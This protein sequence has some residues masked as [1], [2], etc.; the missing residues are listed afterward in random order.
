MKTQGEIEMKPWMIV[1]LCLA[2]AWVPIGNP[3]AEGSVVELSLQQLVNGSTRCVRGV[4][5]SQDTQ[6]VANGGM[7]ETTYTIQVAETLLG[8]GATTV[9]VTIP[10]GDKDGVRIRNAEAPVYE[11]GEE[12]VAFLRTTPEGT[13]TYGWFQ[14][15]YTILDGMVRE[16][17]NTNYDSFRTAILNAVAAS[18]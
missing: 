5:V 17:A 9:T 11:L 15:K 4:V 1:G 13:S 16:L 6:W 8:V 18:K 3:Q 12:V 14:G 2:L 10:G 7:L